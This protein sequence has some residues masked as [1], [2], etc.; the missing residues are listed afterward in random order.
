MMM[1]DKIH[2]SGDGRVYVYVDC[3]FLLTPS[4]S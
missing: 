3:S 2:R 1:M 4:S